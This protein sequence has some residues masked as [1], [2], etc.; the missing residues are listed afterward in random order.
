MKRTIV[1]GV[2]IVV[3][4]LSTLL[5]AQQAGGGAQ[6]A[7]RYVRLAYAELDDKGVK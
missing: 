5:V 2:F 3:S 6:Q 7:P 4:V 1:L